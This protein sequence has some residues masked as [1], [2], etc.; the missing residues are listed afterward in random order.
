[1]LTNNIIYNKNESQVF[2][3]ILV[4]MMSST[5]LAGYLGGATLLI[6]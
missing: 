6:V 1:M 4:V 5:A 2:V 3:A